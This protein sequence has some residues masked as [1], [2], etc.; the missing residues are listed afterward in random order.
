MLKLQDI[1]VSFAD[2]KIL[3]KI[4]HEFIKGKI[5]AIMGPNGSG[6]STL[7]AVIMGHPL[8]RLSKSSRIL[9][10]GKNIVSERPDVRSQKGIFLSFQ[11]PLSLF[12]VTIYQLIRYALNGKKDALIIRRELQKYAQKLGIPEELLSR[13]LNDGFSGG[14]KKKMEVL[15]AAML[16]PD[17]IIFDEIDT[18]V[19]I[20]ALKKITSFIKTLHS[21]NK[22]YI[23]ITHYN[24]ILKYIKP[25][26]VLVLKDGQIKHKGDK[27]LAEKI[28]KD[29]YQNL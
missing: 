11:T 22:T 23:F 16:D 9:F 21:D 27:S 12:G 5:Y 6:K 29:G 19:D 20:D 8:Y 10:K 18:G 17:L 15:Q 3:R 4:N 1:T 2:K 28:E 24:R 14:E 26:E 13:S 25:D 7:A